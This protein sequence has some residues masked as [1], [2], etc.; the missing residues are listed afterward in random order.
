MI[1]MESRFHSSRC[2]SV[3]WR[4]T[5]PSQ[6]GYELDKPLFL[7]VNVSNGLDFWNWCSLKVFNQPVASIDSAYDQSCM[8]SCVRSCVIASCV[9]DQFV[10]DNALPIPMRVVTPAEETKRPSTPNPAEET[11]RP[12]TPKKVC[13]SVFRC[14]FMWLI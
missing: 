7:K 2:L 10:K 13:V 3:R 4:I 8:S 14:M 6:L 11:K 9:A 5:N 12:S 1:R